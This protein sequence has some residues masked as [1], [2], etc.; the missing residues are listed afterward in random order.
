L[1]KTLREVLLKKRDRIPPEEKKEKE[2]AIRKRLYASAD[3]K[4][5]KGILF[6]ASFRS[7]VYTAA[8]IAHAL[9]LKKEVILPRVENKKRMLRLFAINNI[10]EIEPGYMGIPEPVVKK[11]CE[12]DLNDIDVVIV[13]GA[14]FDEK[15][16]RLGYGSGYYDRLFSGIR[17][18]VSGVSKEKLIP[19]THNPKLVLI[20]LAFEE[21][22]ARE[23]PAEPHDVKMDKIITEKRTIDCR[24]KGAK[25]SSGQGIL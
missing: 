10:S 21:Q 22:I 9:K 19:K 1:K 12:R 24:K 13:P 4:R 11:A 17:N 14:G 3:F 16:N 8:C 2:A 18:Q 23:I 20:A 5:A 25:V 6:Y 15:G 7:E